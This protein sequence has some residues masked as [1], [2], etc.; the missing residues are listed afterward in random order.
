M[1]KNLSKSRFIL[2]LCVA[3]FLL[4]ILF[5]QF[6]VLSVLRAHNQ[7]VHQELMLKENELALSQDKLKNNESKQ[8]SLRQEGYVYTDEEV[9]IEE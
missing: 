5:A 6:I 4:V 8:D 7:K 2:I 1:Y 3:I 9:L